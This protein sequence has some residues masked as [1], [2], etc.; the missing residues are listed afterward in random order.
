MLASLALVLWLLGEIV[1]AA[2]PMAKPRCPDKCG[3]VTIPYPFGV[4]SS[5]YYNEWYEITCNSSNPMLTKFRLQVL[6][7]FIGSS[8][9]SVNALMVINCTT[10]NGTWTSTNLG[11]SPYSFSTDNVFGPVNC[12]ATSFFNGLE[13]VVPHCASVW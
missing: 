12:A 2:L 6:Q 9:V 1:A 7:I 8:K 5:C 3:N 11:G 10:E 13:K 4:G